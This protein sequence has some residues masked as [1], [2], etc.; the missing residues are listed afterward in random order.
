MPT[1]ATANLTGHWDA[2]ATAELWKETA[3]ST[4]PANGDGVRAWDD[5]GDAIG[6]ALFSL[7]GASAPA[8]LTSGI[9][10]LSALKFDGSASAMRAYLDNFTTAMAISQLIANNAYH[11]FLA[12]QIDGDGGTDADTFEN[13]AVLEEDGGGYFG[14]HH[15]TVTGQD[16]LLAYN[17]AGAD[18]S[19]SIDVPRGVPIIWEQRHDGGN[20]R[21][22]ANQGSVSSIASGNTG[23][24]TGQLLVGETLYGSGPKKFN[25]RI[26]E[27]LFY[28]AALTGSDYTDTYQYLMDKWTG[29][30]L[31]HALGRPMGF[32]GAGG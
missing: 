16:K 2:S 8:Y 7:S 21:A 18:H 1:F 17:F 11:A 14:L 26:G 23:V 13:P 27:I 20:L 4:H 5:V 15:K 3:M 32:F 10:A 30:A 24:V 19:V 28:N 12:L 29:A 31:T 25:G 6:Y 9:G 22:S